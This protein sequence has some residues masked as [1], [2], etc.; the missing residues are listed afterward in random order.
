VSYRVIT[1]DPAEADAL[2]LFDWL[3]GFNAPAA[4]RFMD[5]FHA[6]AA[7]LSENPGGYPVAE[8]S[9]LY[10]RTVRRHLFR[11]GSTGY[12]LLFTIYEAGELGADVG[13]QVHVLRVLHGSARPLTERAEG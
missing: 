6:A 13:P 2:K 10:T 5:A 12:R 3:F 8:E 1:L 7:S 9:I 4:F 11:G